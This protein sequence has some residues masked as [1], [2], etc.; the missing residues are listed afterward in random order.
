MAQA[1]ENHVIAHAGATLRRKLA[2]EYRPTPVLDPKNPRLHGEKPI[3]HI[4]RS[5]ETFGFNVPVRQGL[6]PARHAERT[7]RS[8]LQGT[9][10]AG[11]P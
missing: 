1:S 5:I 4:A 2:I 10:G 8:Q 9:R 11:R 6:A 3:R 7:L